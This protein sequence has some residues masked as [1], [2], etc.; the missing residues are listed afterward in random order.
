M[1]CPAA[2]S[3]G[4]FL[5]RAWAQQ[6][7]V[8]LLDEPFNGL[9]KNAQDDLARTLRQLTRDGKLVIVSHHNLQTAPA[10]FDQVLLLNGELVAF[11]PTAEVFTPE[12]IEETFSTSVMT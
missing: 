7:H 11:G 12:R 4:R 10:L 5:A 2:S 1:H 8:Y 3:S 6:A 9:D